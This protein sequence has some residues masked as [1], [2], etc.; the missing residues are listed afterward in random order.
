MSLSK[1]EAYIHQI[2]SDFTTHS[3][4]DLWHIPFRV[5][6]Q[7]SQPVPNMQGKTF[8]C[9]TKGFHKIIPKMLTPK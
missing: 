8:M 2:N 4:C 9:L 3:P 1:T 5:W 7:V 6:V